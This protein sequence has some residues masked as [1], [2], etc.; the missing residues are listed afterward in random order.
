MT[1]SRCWAPLN[2]MGQESA[3]RKRVQRGCFKASKNKSTPFLIALVT[4]Q[5][6]GS[7][8]VGANSK[9]HPLPILDFGGMRSL[10]WPMLSPLGIGFLEVTLPSPR[11][12]VRGLSVW[13]FR[14]LPSLWTRNQ[15]LDHARG[16]H[17][18]TIPKNIP[19]IVSSHW[20]PAVCLWGRRER[21]PA[22][23]GC[24]AS[25]FWRKYGWVETSGLTLTSSTAYLI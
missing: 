17:P 18:C 4:L 5:S 22:C 15:D 6:W 9:N 13:V 16:D 21:C 20:K 7:G 24:E 25:C 10:P 12:K 3:E 11:V 8:S 1:F 2:G 19:H 23:A 14:Y